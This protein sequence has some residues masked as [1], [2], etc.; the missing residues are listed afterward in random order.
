MK[1][2]ID[3]PSD[4]YAICK[5]LRVPVKVG[6]GDISWYNTH[7]TAEPYT[8]PD[9]KAIEDEV[10]E[11]VSML[12]NMHPD[13][14]EDIYWSMNGGKG[15]GVAAE[16]TYQEAKARYDAWKKE[17]EEIRIGDEVEYEYGGEKIRFIVTGVKYST[18]YGFRQIMEY[19]D[20]SDV[21][22]YCD[23]D[24]LQKTGR[25]FPEVAELLKKMGDT[26]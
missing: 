26:E 5:T 12:M 6:N 9:R 18:A 2:I 24:A 10:W 23:V 8:E 14:A 13:V 22:E 15:I 17:K 25:H 7:L 20:V 3:V 16:M 21:G 19:E 4:L 1:Y 11:F